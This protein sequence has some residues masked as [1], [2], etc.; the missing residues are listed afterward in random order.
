M[1]KE[2]RLY[3]FLVSLSC[4]LVVVSN[5]AATKISPFIIGG[6]PVDCGIYLFP[7]SFVVMDVL[8]DKFGLREANFA[9]LLALLFNGVAIAY[10]ALVAK[11]PA[12]AGWTGQEAFDA[13]FSSTFRVVLA[14]VLAYLSHFVDNFVFN[15]LRASGKNFFG[16]SIV[17]TIFSQVIDSL[18]FE[19]VAFFGVLEIHDFFTQ[20]GFA[21]FA[22]MVVELVLTAVMALIRCKNIPTPSESH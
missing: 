20:F 5:F 22:A 12:Y 2:S 1:P 6:L 9:T 10:L 16:S 15:R 4:T 3:G 7:L 17:S 8:N 18:I 11:L 19:F 13:V 14:S 21:L